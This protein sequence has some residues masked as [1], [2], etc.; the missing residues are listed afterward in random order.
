MANIPLCVSETPRSPGSRNF[1]F[2]AALVL[3]VGPLWSIVPLSWIFV[4]YSL[5]TGA[6]WQYHAPRLAL[7]I[8]A[9]AEVFFSV[10]YASCSRLVSGPC[11]IPSGDMR[12][13][14]VTF[15]RVLKA[16]LANLP[17]EGYD[18]E[19]LPV[20]RPGSPAE[21]IVQLEKDDPRAIDFRNSLRTWFGK[22][23]WSQIHRQQMKAWLYW[24]IFNARMPE[25]DAIPPPKKKFLDEAL[26]LIEKRSGTVIPE[27]S[28][29][30]ARPMLLTLD[31][32]NFAWRPLVWYLFVYAGNISFKRYLVVN[33]KMTIIWK[34]GV[35]YLCHAPH[36]WN[37]STGPSPVVFLHGLGLG[38]I[39]YAH[40][41]FNLLS[42]TTHRPLLVP[43]Q[44]H[45]SQLIFHPEFLTPKGRHATAASMHGLFVEL[46]WVADEGDISTESVFGGST[47][48]AKRRGVTIVSHSNGSFVH[49]WLLKAH[50]SIVARSCFV[51]PVTF[52]SWEGDVCHNFLYRRPSTALELLMYY[53]VGSE[54]GVT[55]VLQRHF[56][57]SSN[58]LYYEEIPNARDP[59]CTRFFLGGKDAILSA[60]RVRKY[61]SSHGVRKGMAY[62]PDGHHGSALLGRSAGFEE[63]VQWLNGPEL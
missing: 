12:E 19:T 53:F 7:F 15:T 44:P 39:Q 41:I 23:P 9:V 18:E 35:E 50:A 2:Y 56:D 30:A 28:N 48:P 38:L 51:D 29:P 25:L 1:A 57:W 60:E 17:E 11:L 40:I 33:C 61:L 31:P 45:I 24:A 34:D 20:T 42:H 55:N 8:F 37:A 58:S 4:L 32:I 10:H 46:G 22:V 63:L 3:F 14:Q 6:V 59:M 26:T 13:L 43:L 27:G 16:G 62:D 54:L 21:D 5:F 49:A 36:G 52:C 47:V